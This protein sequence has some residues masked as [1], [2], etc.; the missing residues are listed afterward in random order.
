MALRPLR[1]AATPILAQYPSLKEHLATRRR[2]LGVAGAT[3]AAG[4]LAACSRSLQGEGLDGGVS[5]D[6]RVNDPDAVIMNP[7]ENPYPD[8]FFVRI[9]AEGDLYVYLADGGYLTGYVEVSTYSQASYLALI[10]HL[11]QAAERCRAALVDFTYDQM[12]TAAGVDMAEAD[13]QDA[14]DA[15]CQELGNHQDPTIEAVTLTITF[16][17]P[18]A[19]IDGGMGKPSYP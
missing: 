16:L 15:L 12:N 8:Y 9:P 6:A 10:D 11:D 3:L 17:Q 5:P 19:P 7:G 1:R 4:G 2:F 18:D 14:L 13:L